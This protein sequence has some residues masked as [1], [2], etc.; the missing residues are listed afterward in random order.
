MDSEGLVVKLGDPGSC[1]TNPV[2]PFILGQYPIAN[3]GTCRVCVIQN[4]TGQEPK[5]HPWYDIWVRDDKNHAIGGIDPFMMAP[6]P[7]APDDISHPP[8]PVKFSVG[9]KLLNMWSSLSV[10]DKDY[11]TVYMVWGK[12]AGWEG[13]ETMRYDTNTS[14]LGP[15]TAN[16][17]CTMRDSDEYGTRWFQCQFNC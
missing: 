9:A 8:S 5:T 16:N 10:K 17:N 12:P 2:D 7:G 3:G 11:V 4:G 6:G 13:P 15:T 14:S 1:W